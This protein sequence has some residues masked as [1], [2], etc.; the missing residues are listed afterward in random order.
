MVAAFFP[1][2]NRRA[3]DGAALY[4]G[5]ILKTRKVLALPETI[6]RFHEML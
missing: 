5:L 1:P 4:G 6:C 3:P 2:F